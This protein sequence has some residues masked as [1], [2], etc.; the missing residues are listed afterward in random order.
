MKVGPST[1]LICGIHVK[2]IQDIEPSSNNLTW[3]KTEEFDW[4]LMKVDY[5]TLKKRLKQLRGGA[6]KK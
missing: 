3:V 1:N 6:Y 2:E 4:M 5:Q